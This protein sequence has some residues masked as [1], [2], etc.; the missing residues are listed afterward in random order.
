ASDN[1]PSTSPIV[2]GDSPLIRRYLDAGGKVV[3]L[4]APL[5]LITF[6]SLGARVRV[7]LKEMERLIGVAPA[8]NPD[9][10][11]GTPTRHGER[12]GIHQLFRGQYTW[13][14]DDSAVTRLAVDDFGGSTAWVK[15]FNRDVP[16][17][18]YVQLWGF[19]VPDRLSTIREVAEYGL[20]RPAIAG[21]R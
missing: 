10:N 11:T 9:R 1:I 7:D 16:G 2:A 12:W 18:G 14:G 19:S 3:W 20:R 17:S 21:N 15:A 8:F 6:D 4:A 5:G 13:K